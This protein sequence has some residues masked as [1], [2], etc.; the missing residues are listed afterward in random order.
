[1]RLAN[2]SEE[3]QILL[4]RRPELHDSSHA[5]RLFAVPHSTSIARESHFL[6]AA[7]PLHLI[8]RVVRSVLQG[9][10]SKALHGSEPTVARQPHRERMIRSLL[11]QIL[12]SIPCDWHLLEQMRYDTR[13]RWF[14]GLDSSD[15][16]WPQEVHA[17]ARDAILRSGTERQV[18]GELL[19]GLRPIT[20]IVP[21]SFSVDESLVDRWHANLHTAAQ[22][23]EPSSLSLHTLLKAAGLSGNRREID[24]RLIRALEWILTRVCTPDLNSSSL[25]A[26]VG[27]SRRSLYY[28]FDAYQLTPTMAIRN[29]RLEHCKRLLEDVSHGQ[30]TITAIA[31]DY[32]FSSLCSFSRS[33]KQRY[34]FVPRDCRTAGFRLADRIDT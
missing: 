28:L 16:V 11:L 8:D 1:M 7:H 29:I 13:F 20:R 12:Y 15:H 34:G 4:S 5:S 3:T 24:S 33:F 10:A 6:E 9:T 26:G 23:A 30:R 27:M 25:A 31:L 32:G 17:R 14:V 18:F 21:H 19:R 22:P 2:I